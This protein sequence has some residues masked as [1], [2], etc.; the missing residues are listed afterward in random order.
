M[1]VNGIISIFQDD[2]LCMYIVGVYLY[3]AKSARADLL[4]WKFRIECQWELSG[5]CYSNNGFVWQILVNFSSYS[6]GTNI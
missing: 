5:R 3:T 2:Q 1:Q 6:R 4:F